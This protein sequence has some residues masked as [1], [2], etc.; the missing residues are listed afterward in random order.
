M[1]N[2][3]IN[4]IHKSGL[5][6]HSCSSERFYREELERHHFLVKKEDYTVP[7]YENILYKFKFSDVFIFFVSSV[8]C[9][10]G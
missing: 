10:G 3:K 5:F 6:I 7:V 1:Y 9:S 4:N 2:V 8:L